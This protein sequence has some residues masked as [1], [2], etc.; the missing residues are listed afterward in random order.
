MNYEVSLKE[1]KGILYA[2]YYDGSKLVKKSLRLKATKP[3]IAYAQKQIIPNLQM[4]IA[5]GERLF[6]ESKI[7]VFFERVMRRYDSKSY[8]TQYIY[9]KAFQYFLEYFGDID[10]KRIG[11][12]ELDDYV[13][14]LSKRLSSASVKVYL[15]PVSLLFN[16]AIRLDFIQKNPLK[17][18]I[19]PRVENTKRKVY[20]LTQMWQLL[21][22]SSGR[23]RTYLHIA[24]MTGMR[25]G[26][27]LALEWSD[28]DFKKK[29]ITVSKS[30]NRGGLGKTKS[31]KDRYI[32]IMNNLYDYLITIE[33]K[34]G[35]VIGCGYQKIMDDFRSLCSGLGF[36]F[37]GT[38]NVR[39]TFASLMLQA[40][41]SPLLVKEFLG[42]TDLTMIN[43][44]YAHYIE[45]KDDCVKF[46][47]VLAHG[48]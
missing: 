3:N 11:V 28:I 45:D 6:M 23:L 19:K 30:I 29:K 44:V 31:G 43:R 46:G 48:A 22:N 12:L 16:E 14:H 7:S 42:H 17:Y 1:R 35:R 18:A 26:E 32:P 41:E 40:K 34:E 2:H 20:T 5:K 36:F 21:Q 15:A 24:F 4:R 37:E 8:T 25:A 13:E 38:H 10:V 33:P 39:H 27:I 47:A 9:Q